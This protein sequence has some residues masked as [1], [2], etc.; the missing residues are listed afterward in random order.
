[1]PLSAIRLRPFLWY[2]FYNS[3]FTGLSVGTIFTL[4]QPLEPSV[5][6]IGGVLLA[7]AML[8]IARFY[9]AIM[10]RTWFYRIS[11]G[12]EAVMVVMVVW[13]LLVSYSYMTAMLIYAGYQLTFAFGS[14]LVRAETML[15]PR[16]QLLTFLDVAKQKGYLVGMAAAYLFYKA[17]EY[18]FDMTQNQEQVYAIHGLLLIVEA[19]TIAMLVKAF[20]PPPSPLVR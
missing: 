20:G 8:F 6:S 17:M 2:K 10:N 19:V 4:Y 13:F 11:L 18:G 15:L 7:L 1:M 12:V 16:R 14:Y 9:T 3:L 5:Y